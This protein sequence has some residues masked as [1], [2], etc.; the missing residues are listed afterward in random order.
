MRILTPVLTRLGTVPV[1]GSGFQA[2]FLVPRSFQVPRGFNGAW[3]L[4]S[5]LQVRRRLDWSDGDLTN[6]A[7]GT[8]TCEQGTWNEPGTWKPTWNLEPGTYST[9]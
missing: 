2:G 9:Q 7:L 3:F 1:P 5:E 6:P 4:G 8:G